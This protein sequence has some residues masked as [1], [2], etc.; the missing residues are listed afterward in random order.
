MC[1]KAIIR[2]CRH[3]SEPTFSYLHEKT[4][5]PYSVLPDYMIKYKNIVEIAVHIIFELIGRIDHGRKQYFQK[6]EFRQDLVT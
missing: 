2:R 3:S 6:E 4:N 1:F 5:N